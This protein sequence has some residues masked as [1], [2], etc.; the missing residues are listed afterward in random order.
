MQRRSFA[1]IWH[2]IAGSFAISED[3]RPRVINLDFPV[4]P[5]GSERSQ[6][7]IENGAEKLT[8]SLC[9]VETNIDQMPS[10]PLSLIYSH[11]TSLQWFTLLHLPTLLN[12]QPL[13]NRSP[14]RWMLNSKYPCIWTLNET[15]RITSVH[16]TATLLYQMDLC[17]NDINISAQVITLHAWEVSTYGTAY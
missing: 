9:S 6:K 13:P 1:D 7:L 11:Q 5:T 3:T 16:L 2:R 8:V 17:L 14:T 15:F 4:L 10:S 12:N